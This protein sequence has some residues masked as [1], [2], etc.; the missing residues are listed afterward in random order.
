MLYYSKIKGSENAIEHV[1]HEFAGVVDEGIKIA[2]DKTPE[3]RLKQLS[4]SAQEARQRVRGSSVSLLENASRAN[5]AAGGSGLDL[6]RLM[7]RTT[8][9]QTQRN[10]TTERVT[11][12]STVLFELAQLLNKDVV[13]LRTSSVSTRA[14]FVASPRP[15]SPSEPTPSVPQTVQLIKGNME[16]KSFLPG[17]LPDSSVPAA[18][19]NSSLVADFNANS[20]V[21]NE[22]KDLD[23][24]HIDDTA[25]VGV[26]LYAFEA[27]ADSQEQISVAEG[28]TVE[29]LEKD[30]DG[31][32]RL[33]T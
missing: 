4:A 24:P 19:A 16:A 8:Q 1:V 9:V 17:E 30:S 6:T 32:C 31:T 27:Q 33:C 28:Q 11:L 26:M 23:A 15:P 13:N 25:I 22:R 14:S 2:F 5:V 3:R 18:I 20:V 21:G 7:A 29:I 12:P 10:V